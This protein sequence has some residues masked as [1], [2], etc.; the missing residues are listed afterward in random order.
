MSS[1]LT[2]EGVR[3]GTLSRRLLAVSWACL[4]SLGTA[5]AQQQVPPPP[6]TTTPEPP[7]VS[8]A[9]QKAVFE[10]I[11][12]EVSDLFNKCKGAVVRIEATDPLERRGGTGF[13][14]DPSGTIYTSYTVAGHSW[15]FTF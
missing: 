6:P 11:Q 13:F 8:A 9:Q 2:S 10:A 7:P 1:G 15:N 14:V 5:R 4:A 12:E 3:A